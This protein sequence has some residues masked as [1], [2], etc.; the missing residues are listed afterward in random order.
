M[1]GGGGVASKCNYLKYF[2]Q[3][4]LIR[5][6]IIINALCLAHLLSIPEVPEPVPG[7]ASTVVGSEIPLLMITDSGSMLRAGWSTG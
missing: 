3:N 5:S 7:T 2:F 4:G 1:G 6:L